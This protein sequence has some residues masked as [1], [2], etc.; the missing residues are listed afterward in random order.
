MSPRTAARK[1]Q[2]SWNS[3]C[4]EIARFKRATGALPTRGTNSALAG[5]LYEQ[6]ARLE[7]GR[8]T[9]EQ[10]AAFKE[11]AP[12]FAPKRK[13]RNRLE[14][15]EAFYREHG[16]L[17]LRSDADPAEKALNMYLVM[18]LRTRI[19]TG[20]ISASDMLRAEAIPGA[21]VIRS[22]PDQ[23]AMLG[24]LAEYVYTHSLMP[25][26]DGEHDKLTRWVT[27][28]TKGDP[29]T[30]SP[31]LR[32]RHL[33]IEDLRSRTTSRADASL[34]QRLAEAEAFCARHG[35]RPGA[36]SHLPLAERQLADWLSRRINAGPSSIP[37]ELAARRLKAIAAVPTYGDVRWRENLQGLKEY[38]SSTGALPTR[39]EQPN[40]NW[41]A[42]Q[43]RDFRA[44]IMPDW[45][46]VELH[47]VP[48][49][50]IHPK[51]A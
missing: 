30:K 32:A 41:L 28:N 50:I 17:P 22:V 6:H 20:K 33:A 47:A 44:G 19:R 24:A 18:D 49:L 46:A 23:A 14:Q 13:S 12:G 34:L 27:N 26:M 5:W 16:R 1:P 8:L 35:V 29:E 43:R 36:A 21:T 31:A 40:Y 11:L 15:L 25:V 4:A 48:G 3:R 39:W 51:A 37:D 38:L 45:K 9:A 42:V 2:A 10:A 7:S